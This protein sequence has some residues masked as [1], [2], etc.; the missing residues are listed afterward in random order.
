MET[1]YKCPECGNTLLTADAITRVDVVWGAE[2]QAIPTITDLEDCAITDKS[3]ML[4]HECDHE[5]WSPAFINKAWSQY[6]PPVH[7][8]VRSQVRA[9]IRTAHEHGAELNPYLVY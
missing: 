3:W 4:C 7:I 6:E 5:D 8:S 1:E 2:G 9:A